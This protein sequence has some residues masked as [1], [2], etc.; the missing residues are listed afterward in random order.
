MKAKGRLYRM[1]PPQ[2][3]LDV[4]ALVMK[5]VDAGALLRCCAVSVGWHKVGVMALIYV[6]E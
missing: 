1:V 6:E 2:L 3:P 4:V 5:Y